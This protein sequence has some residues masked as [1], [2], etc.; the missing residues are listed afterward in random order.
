MRGIYD[1]GDHY[2]GPRTIDGD[3][4]VEA[5]PI[6]IGA[7]LAAFFGRPTSTKAASADVYDHVYIPSTSDFD[8]TYSAK[9]PVT[10]V[11]NLDV[12]SSMQFSDLNAS[13][14]EMAINNGEF[15]MATVGFV[16]GH[17]QQVAPIT[18]S[19]NT[20][21]RWTWD[22]TSVSIGGSAN[23]DV[24][25][26]TMSIED[27]IEAQH[28][29]CGSTYPSRIKRTGFRVTNIS[30]T[31]KFDNQDEYQQ[32]LSRSERELDVTLTGNVAVSSGYF[33]KLRL[34]IPL[35]R[36][37]EFKPAAGGPGSIEVGFTSKGVYSVTSGTAIRVTLTNTQTAY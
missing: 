23:C 20:G 14:L 22:Q 8:T 26:L 32:F 12:G 21:K 13:T 3:L 6:A 18:P 31:L 29:L 28:T 19:F 34:Q 9:V 36:H 2:D 10:I 25:Q 5:Q 11:K 16:G 33:N 27:A 1:E 35:L 37:T 30:G 15:L 7:M 4:G 24:S 17:F